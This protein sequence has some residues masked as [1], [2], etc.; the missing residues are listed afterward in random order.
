VRVVVGISD[1]QVKRLCVV[2]LLWPWLRRLLG[3]LGRL[4]QRDGRFRARAWWLVVV[5]LLVMAMLLLVV[6]V[7]VVV[8]LLLVLVLAG[9][10][11]VPISRTGPRGPWTAHAHTLVHVPMLSPQVLA[12]A[13]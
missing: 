5:M 4:L 1:Y 10:P 6:V 9:D 7:A 12:G 11:L 2:R 13:R 8:L 3:P